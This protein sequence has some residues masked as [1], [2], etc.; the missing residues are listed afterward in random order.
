MCGIVA[1][2]GG[3][4]NHLTRVL[5]GM[6]AIIYRAP[7]STGIGLFGDD[8]EPIRL[9]KSLGSVVQLLGALQTENVYGHPAALLHRLLA[10]DGGEPDW[11][12]RQQRLLAFEGFENPSVAAPQ[13]PPDFDALVNLRT[14]QPARLVPGC[15]GK[16]RFRAE[17]RIRSRQDL[18]A[19]IQSL[20]TA[21]DLSP[22]VI[23][24]LF[25]DALVE[26]IDRR[27]RS[28][29]V[30]AADAEVLAAFDDLFEA[31]RVGARVKRLRRNRAPQFP[32]PPNARKEL[33]QCLIETVLRV[34][35]DYC[36]DGVCCLFRLLDAALLS[37]M[38]GDPTLA[39]TIDR[40]L[41]TMWLP[42]QRPQRVDWRS[43]YAAEKALN[44]YGWAGAA[45]LAYLQRD[46]FF[47]AAAGDMERRDL[48]T[49]EAVLP[50]Q[51]DPML[52]RYLVTP[53][54]AH[55]RWA[56][57]SAVTVENAHPF[58]DARR[59][60]ALALNGQF[61]SR[62]EARLRTFLDAVCGY[63]L[64]SENSA[65]YAVLLWGHFYDQLKSEQQRSDL[66]RQQV[67]EDMADIAIGSQAVDFSIY[68]RVRNRTPADLDQLAF[69]AAA[70]QIVQNG[71]QVAVAGISLA[72]PRR[73]Y[74][75][76][77]NRPVFIVR[78]LE[79]DDFMVVSDINAALGLF[80]Q[81]LVE[82]TISAL[83]TLKKRK[84]TAITQLT[85][86]GANRSMLRTRKA[87]FA[88]EREAL[89]AP[90][91]VEIHPLDGEEIFAL[92]ETGLEDGKVLRT[93]AILDFDG[94][95]L[96][97]VEPFET[98]LD[99]VT[100]RKDVDRSFHET[101]LR[102]IPE[103]FRYI[104][105]VYGSPASG[106]GPTI[107]LKTRVLRR[108]F[109]RH[110]EGLQRLILVG[111]GSTYHM[112]VTAQRFF[113]ELLP[114]TVVEA[115]RPGDIED[116]KQRF[117]PQQ[118]LIVLLSWSSTTA[119]MV[120][121]AQQLHKDRT[122]MVG[123]TE[124]C[125]ADMA[126][127]CAK[128]GGVMPIYSGE[129][130]TI[131]GIKSTLCMLLCL[132][133]IAAWLASEKGLT[134][135]LAPIFGLLGDLADRIDAHNDNADAIAFSRQV[136]K[137]AAK[138]EAIVAVSSVTAAGIG[139]EIVL[140]LEEAA[141]YAVG[142]WY[143]FDDI[144]TGDPG[145][146]SRNRYVIVHATQRSQIDTAVSV[147]Q[148]LAEADIDFAVVTCPNRHQDRISQLSKRQ[149]L[150]LPWIDDRSQPY[151]DLAFYYRL[152][153]D[154]GLASGHG[155][156]VAPRNRTKS[157]TVTRTRPK[158]RRSPAAEL[159]RLAAGTSTAP[160]RP[161]EEPE[162]RTFAWET[163]IGVPGAAAVFD[164]LRHLGE[165]LGRDEPLK[166][167]GIYDEA[168]V[169]HLGGLL[170]G[171]RSDINDVVLV[172]H[173]PAA[174]AV[175][176]DV[177]AIWRRLINLP[178]REMPLGY[179]PREAAEDTLV[180]VAATQAEAIRPA[181]ARQALE[182]QKIAWLGP[183]P[184]GWLNEG[185]TTN[186]RFCLSS[187]DQRCPPAWLYAGFNLLIARAWYHHAPQ[188]AAIVQRH[189]AAA[190]HAITTVL[191]D[192]V[193]LEGLR[194]VVEA[195]NRYP[196]AFF[197]SPFGGPG[198]VWEDHFDQTGRIMMVHHYPGHACHGPIVTIDGNAQ[199]KYVEL[200]NRTAMLARYGDA[201][202]EQWEEQFLEGMHLDAFLGDP[203]TMPLGR[204]QAPFYADNRWF[205]PVLQPDYETR[206]DNLIILDMTAERA[207][208]AMLDELSLLGSRVPRLVVITQQ[209]R[210]REVGEKTFFGFPVS[211]LL[212]L[213]P[214]GGAPIPDMH[215]PLVLNAVGAALAAVWKTQLSLAQNA[216]G[217]TRSL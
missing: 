105:D 69:I 137:T 179:W 110:L 49:A 7:D 11:E 16:A 171:D 70:R 58:M 116:P 55:G 189:F 162:A 187:A 153:L 35:E 12:Q 66:V 104:L 196:T 25:R 208:P 188:K 157:S 33:W 52:L 102:E 193:L 71:G 201:T 63:R 86:K 42:S 149:C 5:T 158:Y 81:A 94:R 26:T 165:R 136:A 122:L 200:M 39:E 28:D 172:P 142:R 115:L 194:A 32:K 119:E 148:R 44:V 215:L 24:T 160:A 2:F 166:A 59:Q 178:M 18:S 17:Y 150:V 198:R 36:R 134:K 140:K 213:P 56:M 143:S 217:S 92:V 4:G 89:L 95:A 169:G 3:A 46:V 183:S 212:V 99:P 204:P 75:A 87:A 131:A 159:K 68:H 151:I 93:V 53:I 67:K 72:S 126:L 8:H 61:D 6:S 30:S 43:L 84:T 146:W 27:R 181:H 40:V 97:D 47:P 202:V 19:L 101:H 107:D 76:S 206:R 29:A 144:L 132:H 185:L 65:E 118:D 38:G 138:A 121:L 1:Y 79:N 125:F 155:S 139:Q 216:N 135:R 83:R 127:A 14:S 164:E 109:G 147:M 190:A 57:Q 207:L 113:A 211:N 133:L 34:P 85:A 13:D 182:H 90:F 114:E 10:V 170:F 124:K 108:R 77:H 15:R 9:R 192:T 82:K 62:V 106:A 154:L 184:P 210:I 74:V 199:A 141:W 168:A 174:A 186:G 167:I 91:A 195:N 180:L 22:L 177:S 205:L 129:E 41:D 60:R 96:P 103:R 163:A 117:L 50:G 156:G 145:R 21:Y 100:V 98:C 78:R 203:S 20:I 48:M 31:T 123:I 128:S 173:D 214:V 197:I 51:T 111:T 73:L 88:R 161:R 191:E 23:H 45:A 112:A 64:R 54:I 130:V 152:A 176:R 80:P 120:N 37:P 209:D 175:V